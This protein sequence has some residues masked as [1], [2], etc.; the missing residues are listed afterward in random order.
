MKPNDNPTFRAS[1]PD[2]RNGLTSLSSTELLI[3]GKLKKH[4][5]HGPPQPKPRRAIP[6]DV[7][8]LACFSRCR[9][10]PL[11]VCLVHLPRREA[12]EVDNLTGSRPS[13]YSHQREL[14]S[15][16]SDAIPSRSPSST[17]GTGGITMVGVLRAVAGQIMHATLP[18]PWLRRDPLRRAEYH[19]RSSRHGRSCPPAGLCHTAP[20]RRST[21]DL[22]GKLLNTLYVLDTQTDIWKTLTPMQPPGITKP[23]HF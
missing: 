1:P 22:S 16:P 4:H 8:W 19:G 7:R 11:A 5:N 15:S 23:S 21:A 3:M 17:L 12:G 18:L 13:E 14:S 10:W 20:D 9:P 2:V 6:A